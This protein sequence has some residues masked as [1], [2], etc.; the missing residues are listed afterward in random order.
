MSDHATEAAEKLLVG[1]LG[2]STG[3]SGVPVRRAVDD[4]QK[5][6]PMVIVAGSI[7]DALIPDGLYSV[8]QIDLKIEIES[9]FAQQASQEHDAIIAAIGEAIPTIGKY[10]GPQTYF[11]SVF[12]GP[13]RSAEETRNEL[14]RIYTFQTY[15]VGRLTIPA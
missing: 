2:A 11:E 7:R 13:T 6:R 10:T 14:V 1:V 8:Y 3:L 12:F 15:L 4:D 9:Q 5:T